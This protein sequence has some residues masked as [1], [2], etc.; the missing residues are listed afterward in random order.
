ALTASMTLVRNGA[1]WINKAPLSLANGVVLTLNGGAQTFT[2]ASGAITRTG[3]GS[4]DVVGGT[5]KHAGG[6]ITGGTAPIML[7]SS[8]LQISSP[9]AADFLWHGPGSLSGN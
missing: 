4:I 5:F 9:N 7:D 3:T 8:N 1:S 2:H 6:T